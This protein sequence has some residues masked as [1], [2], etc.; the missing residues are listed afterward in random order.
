MMPIPRHYSGMGASSSMIQSKICM[1]PGM[2]QESVNQ[3]DQ[4][5]ADIK[6]Q[7]Q[8]RR[9]TPFGN[10]TQQGQDTR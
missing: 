1:M 8:Q 5:M 3:M 4:L 2:T 6:K 10:Y 7:I 9:M